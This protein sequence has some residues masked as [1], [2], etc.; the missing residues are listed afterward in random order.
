MS[1]CEFRDC[2]GLHY[3]GGLFF[4]DCTGE[5]FNSLIVG[6]EGGESLGSGAGL[7]NCNVTV[8]SCT[9][10]N[11]ISQNIE[12][13]GAL[14]LFDSDLSIIYNSVFWNNTT[15][16]YAESMQIGPSDGWFDVYHCD[17]Q[18]GWSG[19]GS[20]N[21]DVDPCFVASGEWDYCLSA[22]GSGQ[23]ADSPCINSGYG[24]V[25]DWQLAEYS[26]R[27]D[28]EPDI[29]TVDMGYRRFSNPASDVAQEWIEQDLRMIAS[30]NPF[31]GG[32]TIRQQGA[33]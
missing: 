32:T 5:L 1:H 21:I 11:N 19:Y 6:N 17:V 24:F 27:T 31:Q 33:A 7:L 3:A 28:Q 16:G 30:P 25:G 8:A 29:G 2:H 20:G 15:D 22:I 18:Y 10:V 14:V 13:A 26:T 4:E 12:P 23:V 9:F